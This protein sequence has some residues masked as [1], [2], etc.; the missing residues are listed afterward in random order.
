[1]Q[2]TILI[3]RLILIIRPYRRLNDLCIQ[4][5]AILFDGENVILPTVYYTLSLRRRQERP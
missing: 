5:D 3:V 1:M 2:Q 4:K